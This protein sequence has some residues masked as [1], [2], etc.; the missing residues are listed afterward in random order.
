MNDLAKC[1]RC[2]SQPTLDHTR[3][4]GLRYFCQTCDDAVFETWGEAA[5]YWN[6]GALVP[7]SRLKLYGKAL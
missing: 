4:E 7:R 6:D 3:P 1:P 2:Q 5:A